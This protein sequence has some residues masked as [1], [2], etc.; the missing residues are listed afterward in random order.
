VRI[1]RIRIGGFGSL[2]NLDLFWPEGKLLLVVDSNETGKTTF[3]EAIVAALYGLPKGRVGATRLRDLRRP[4]S[5]APLRVGLELTA[6]ATR[7]SV[8]RDLENGTVRIVDR[9]RG[10]DVTRDFLR[11][12]GRDIFGERATGGLSEQL[13]RSTSYV[14]Q[15]VLDRDSLDST[16][17]VELARIADSG[18]GEASVVRA[19]KVLETARREM[20]EAASGA[21]VSVDTE[22]TRLT[23]TV[24]ALGAERARLAG[25]RAAAAEAS[26]K[27]AE[28]ARTRDTRRRRVALA[29]LAVVEA[30]RRA[31]KKRLDEIYAAV[32]ARRAVES[33]AVALAAG[34]ELFSTE[35]LAEIDRVRAERGGRPQ[36][37]AAE[38]V[39]L[40]AE[41]RAAE[42]E[43]RDRAR[44]FGPA[45]VLPDEDRTRLAALLT[46]VAETADEAAAA[47]QALETQWEELKK[48]GLAEDL[49]R[50]EALAPVDRAFLQG[51]EE[52]RSAL[53]LEGIKLDRKVADAAALASIAAGERNERV[54]RARLLVF[55]AAGLVPVLVYFLLPG[56]QAPA[57]VTA[58]AGAFALALGLFGGISWMQG[59]RHRVADEARAREE[60]SAAR[61]KAV[62]VRR[63]LSDLRLRLDRTARAGGLNDGVSLLK[64][65]RRVRAAEEKRR[66]LV[67]RVSRRDAVVERRRTLEAELDP[68]R[69]A[70]GVGA[71]LPRPED[72]RR[73]LGAL[74][75]LDK[76]IQAART[77]ESVR[78][79]EADRLGREEAA[80]AE[81]EAALSAALRRVGAPA[82]LSMAE[83]LHF[84]E[85]G[86]RAAARRKEIL[87]VELP[88]RR[89]A[90]RE[91]E[92]PVLA[93]RVRALDLEIETRLAD[94]GGRRPAEE[95]F[96]VVET[97]EAARRA[98]EDALAELE[99]AEVA[100]LAAERELATAAREGGG[101]A[102][103]AE[104]GL[105]EAEAL[106]ARAV[107]FRDAL[108][109]ARSSLSSA[110][111][112]VYGDFRRG[113]SEASRVILSSWRLPYEMLEFADDLSL[114]AVV[115]G[116]HV[117]TKTEIDLG[118]ST[119]ARE[120]LHL[121][122][123]LAALR[124]L[125]TGAEGVPLL[126]DDPLIGADDERFVSV[127][128][129]LV[130]NVLE[131]RP[132][133]LVS[134]H[135]WRHERLLENLPPSVRERIEKISLSPFSSRQLIALPAVRETEIEN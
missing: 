103:E 70:L 77:R 116:G 126:L 46:S 15:N 68:F 54:K 3:C 41:V 125:G 80:V 12:G 31:L 117:A 106:L 63:R 134:C 99:A 83:A 42:A 5:G 32:E 24:E 60:E 85:S 107:L 114:S 104:E 55:I 87:E 123:R 38:R 40:E 96:S 14:P 105:S 18:G 101:S 43:V 132:V 109:L 135:G 92:I 120:Q 72:C 74:E 48:A 84:V 59:A 108:D 122:A 9:D 100:R 25:F 45:A 50:L 97:P 73:A 27:L 129:F 128:T 61:K 33:E 119:G 110:A 19:L 51:A 67:A 56:S 88:A 124:Y 13:L 64:A 52:E 4:R 23:K 127:M 69:A 89:E 112:S 29:N 118:L 121:T 6:D 66:T 98:A 113:L 82:G 86:R 78:A 95:R 102:R 20:P 91:D 34:A 115:R 79:R 75:E 7:W 130:A 26:A 133:L 65:H 22:V 1:E 131:E 8:D 16:L 2:S 111:A 49:Q 17:T 36:T 39:V 57:H 28:R 21:A 35:A 53:E 94:L 44:R 10:L 93:G 30:E 58:A 90:A 37:L 47:E 62:E 81:I 11:G 76:G 71:G